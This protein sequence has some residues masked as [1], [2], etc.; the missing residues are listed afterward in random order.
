[1]QLTRVNDVTI[2]VLSAT[3]TGGDLAAYALPAKATIYPPDVS[4]IHNLIIITYTFNSI[5]LH[6]IIQEK[7][8]QK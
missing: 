5:M 1:M 7:G 4:Y 3:K 2:L 8:E 6:I